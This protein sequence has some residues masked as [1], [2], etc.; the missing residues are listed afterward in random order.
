M[1]IYLFILL[2]VISIYLVFD[3]NNE[4]FARNDQGKSLDFDYSRSQFRS[5]ITTESNS[6]DKF[7][8]WLNYYGS[9]LLR[10]KQYEIK[11][12]TPDTTRFEENCYDIL[13]DPGIIK[14]VRGND[15]WGQY[16][17]EISAKDMITLL[18]DI[19]LENMGDINLI[20]GHNDVE[21]GIPL[22]YKSVID[23]FINE[24]NKKIYIFDQENDYHHLN[25]N[26]KNKLNVYKSTDKIDYFEL[27]TIINRE[28]KNLVFIIHSQ[29][30]YHKDT[31]DIKVLNI[32]LTG[33]DTSDY[34]SAGF[35]DYNI[36]SL[37]HCDK[38]GTDCSLSNKKDCEA[39]NVSQ[40]AYNEYLKDM[41]EQEKI[42]LNS[43]C[44]YKNAD[45]KAECSS[46]NIDGTTGIWDTKCMADTDC[47]YFGSKGNN[48]YE[49]NRGGCNK[50]SGICELPLNMVNIGYTLYRKGDLYRPLCHNCIPKEGCIGKD[51]SQC[52][53]DQGLNPDYAFYGDTDDRESKKTELQKQGLKVSDIRLR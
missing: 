16:K 36:K 22:T 17:N 20:Q 25:F 7:N 50:D 38:R 12:L 13:D 27:T 23:W 51:C 35:L 21:Q 48:N 5:S 40:E 1:F 52:C 8:T 18:E 42:D 45:T 39:T 34:A 47:P 53:E 31:S 19:K 29:M 37:L 41:K 9:G 33:I 49:N 26:N 15:D 14:E 3:N 28:L 32:K 2:L 46:V 6:N 44:F 10:D 30:Y 11:E 24:L 43:T 4:H